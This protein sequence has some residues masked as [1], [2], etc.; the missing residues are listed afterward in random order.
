VVRLR[1]QV[2][3]SRLAHAQADYSVA[4]RRAVLANLQNSPEFGADNAERS[5]L[6]QQ[7]EQLALETA[8]LDLRSPISGLV[9]TPRLNDQVGSYLTAGTEVVEVADP[10]ILRARVYVSEHD[11]SRFHTGS[12]VRLLANGNAKKSEASVK[13]IEPASSEIPA[14]LIDLSQY[15][16]LHPPNFY[17]VDVD[18][19]NSDG[20]LKPGMVGTAKI[21]G[22]RRSLAGGGW[23]AIR[24][25]FGRRAW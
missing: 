20:R 8:Q 9:L 22:E 18:V 16:G 17:V 12:R 7:T 23:Q 13:A 4:Q 2:L 24:D 3:D 1:N 19:S 10:S 5:R 6:V 25:F 15:K 14:G 11:L 21:Y